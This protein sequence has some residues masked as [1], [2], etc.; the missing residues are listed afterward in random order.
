MTSRLHGTHWLLAASLLACGV[1]LAARFRPA[2]DSRGAPQADTPQEQAGAKAPAP[3][4]NLRIRVGEWKGDGPSLPAGGA[5]A[6]D[7]AS[8]TRVLLSRTPRVYQTEPA[9][10]LPTP[11]LEVRALRGEGRLFFRLKWNDATRNAPTAPPRK[12]GEGGVPERL[13]KRPTG[14]TASFADAAAVMVPDRWTGPAFPSLLMGDRH[15]PARLFYWGAPRGAEELTATGRATPQPAGRPVAHR[16]RHDEGRW[17]LVLEVPDQAE[18]TPVAFAVWDGEAG[19][20]DGLKWFSIWYVLA[21]QER[22]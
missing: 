22:P 9:R 2:A 4:A 14:E 7:R 19:D 21:G 3:A 20:R 12:T 17:T 5:A 15:S 11:A 6:W 10:A 18:G 8:P 16:A 13:Y 1:L